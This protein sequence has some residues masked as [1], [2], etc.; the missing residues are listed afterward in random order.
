[1]NP[2]PEGNA[3]I[4]CEGSFGTTNGKTAHGLVRRSQRYQILSVVDSRHDQSDAGR[5]LDGRRNGI[6]IHGNIRKAVET[7]RADGH[8]A[9]HLVI[10]LAPDGGRLSGKARRDLM[11]AIDLGLHIDSGLHDF[12]SEDSAI[13]LA[14][15]QRGDIYVISD[16]SIVTS[17]GQT[18]NIRSGQ[19]LL[20]QNTGGVNIGGTTTG[21][22]IEEKETG[23]ELNVTPQ[24]TIHDHVKL[25]IEFKWT[26]H[27]PAFT[28]GPLKNAAGGRGDTVK[29][30]EIFTY[31][32]WTQSKKWD[33]EG[34]P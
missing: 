23:V 16:P 32:Y 27:N 17:N 30:T 2:F 31:R 7:A 11:E 22:G 14:A 10:G 6:L 20:L 34:R 26:G 24:I 21:T 8:S 28:V 12:L 3:I 15:E 33:I 9:T 5:L 18:A 25:V 4:Y 13:R 19:T 29:Y 1:M